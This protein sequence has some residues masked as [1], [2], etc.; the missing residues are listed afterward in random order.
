MIVNGHEVVLRMGPGWHAAT[1][2]CH[3]GDDPDRLC[4]MW[5]EDHFPLDGCN[6]VEWLDAASWDDLAHFEGSGD[7]P[8]PLTLVAFDGVEGRIDL[9]FTAKGEQ[10]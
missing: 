1:I 9:A 8:L 6:I 10:S 3:A 5:T 4:R 7:I 2:V